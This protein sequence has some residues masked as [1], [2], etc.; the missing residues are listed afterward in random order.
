MFDPGLS[1][2]QQRG[3]WTPGI[4]KCLLELVWRPGCLVCTGVGNGQINEVKN[5][6]NSP[7]L[8]QAGDSVEASQLSLRSRVSIPPMFVLYSATAGLVTWIC[9]ISYFDHLLQVFWG[10]IS[11][12]CWCPDN[13]LVVHPPGDSCFIRSPGNH[14]WWASWLCARNVVSS[15][16]ALFFQ[17]SIFFFL[18]VL[19]AGRPLSWRAARTDGGKIAAKVDQW[20]SGKG[21]SQT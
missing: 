1:V 2:P 5:G 17:N 16:V 7:L 13:G 20:S 14:L 11:M 3:L 21:L 8:D 10:S 19:V 9:L 6:A 18:V 15:E 4:G 12:S